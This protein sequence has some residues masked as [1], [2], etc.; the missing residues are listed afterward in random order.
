MIEDAKPKDDIT[1]SCGRL[2]SDPMGPYKKM[3]DN[4]TE[5]NERLN[6][7]DYDTQRRGFDALD[8]MSKVYSL[9]E[10]NDIPSACTELDNVERQM[11]MAACYSA[12]VIGLYHESTLEKKELPYL[13]YWLTLQHKMSREDYRNAKKEMITFRDEAKSYALTDMW[14]Q[15]EK[16]ARQY[17]STAESL[18]N[19]IPS[20]R[21]VVKVV[22]GAAVA[23]STIVGFIITVG[24]SIPF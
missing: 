24:I 16:Q 4:Y 20:R 21:R 18:N 8:Y 13:V 1:E 17:S 19:S 7:L 23:V 22:A 3:R 6:R 2:F 9:A 14:I 15:G 12:M 10:K 11:R 5:N